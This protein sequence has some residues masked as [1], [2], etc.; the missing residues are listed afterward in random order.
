MADRVKVTIHSTYTEWIDPDQYGGV[1]KVHETFRESGPEIVCNALSSTR[2]GG[3]F[4]IT[5]V[6]VE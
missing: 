6:D 3:E 1:D 4:E 2:Y 5:G